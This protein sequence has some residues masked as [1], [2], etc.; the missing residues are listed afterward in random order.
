MNTVIA[1]P[2]TSN[3]AIFDSFDQC[4][5]SAYSSFLPAVRGMQQ[6]EIDIILP[7]GTMINKV[8]SNVEI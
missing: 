3:L 1:D 6:V 4:L 7:T 2:N 5:P 8:H